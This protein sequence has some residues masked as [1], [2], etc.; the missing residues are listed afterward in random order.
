MSETFYTPVDISE[1]PD[2][3]DGYLPENVFVHFALG[4]HGDEKDFDALAEVVN[5]SDVVVPEVVGWGPEHLKWLRDVSKSS[6]VN[7]QKLLRHRAGR[8]YVTDGFSRRL[9]ETIQG[10]RKSIILIDAPKN[11]PLS[12]PHNIIAFHSKLTTE[13]AVLKYFYTVCARAEEGGAQREKIMIE[14]LGP[15]VTQA[16][17]DHPMLRIQ[18]NVRVAVILGSA[19]ESV[20]S[21]LQASPHTTGQVG[22]SIS[23]ELDSELAERGADIKELIRSNTPVGKDLLRQYCDLYQPQL[24]SQ[25][26]Q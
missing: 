20:Y 26:T 8:E 2:V 14:S 19:H 21:H 18:N 15:F 1:L 24:T 22:A 17:S 16:V 9:A 7:Y 12:N 13:A 11:T 25:L 23:R 10:K 5:E 4:P 3:E 6:H